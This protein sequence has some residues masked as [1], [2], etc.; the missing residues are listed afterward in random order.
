[1]K[2]FKIFRTLPHTLSV[3]FTISIISSAHA[4]PTT[5]SSATFPNLTNRFGLGFIVGEPTAITGKY[6]VEQ[7]LAFDMGLSFFVGSHLLVYGDYLWHSP[8][9]F[10]RSN[11]FVSQLNPYMGIGAGFYIW[12]DRERPP[13]WRDERGTGVGLYARVPF[14]IE[15]SPGYPPLGVYLEIVPAV[16]VVPGIDVSFDGGLGIRYYF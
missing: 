7:N 2:F 5:Q 12:S 15:W 13:G 16:A 14:G 9:L 8:G 10:G 11:R 3:L 4:A 6:W 1:M